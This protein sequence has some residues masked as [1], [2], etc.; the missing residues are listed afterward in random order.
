MWSKEISINTNASK[1]QIW[2]IWTDVS[3]WKSWDSQVVDSELFESFQQ[4][5]EGILTPKGG[6]KTKFELTEV[7]PNHSFTTTSKLPLGKMK[8]I[9]SIEKQNTE[10]IITH[11]VE[12]SGLSSFIFSKFIGEKLIKELPEA[13]DKLVKQAESI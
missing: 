10:L 8:V 1:D 3:N 5:S 13:L 9:H 11:K 2:K 7:T 4:G 12:I 6:P